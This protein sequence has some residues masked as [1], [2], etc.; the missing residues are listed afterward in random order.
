[1]YEGNGGF[2]VVVDF[3]AL[4]SAQ[5]FR[6]LRYFPLL[7]SICGVIVSSFFES[8][9]VLYIRRSKITDVTPTKKKEKVSLQVVVRFI[10]AHLLLPQAGSSYRI[11]SKGCQGFNEFDLSS[12]QGR[13]FMIIH[14]KG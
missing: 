7:S 1:M 10:Q 5:R 11:S 2:V 12:S 8:L 3:I 4:F 6:R 14:I 9:M 13:N